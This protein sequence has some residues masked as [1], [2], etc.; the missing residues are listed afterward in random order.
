[1]TVRPL[2]SLAAV[3]LWL[4]L[5]ALW[6]AW[7]LVAAVLRELLNDVFKVRKAT[8]RRWVPL[9]RFPRWGRIRAWLPGRRRQPPAEARPVRRMSSRKRAN[10]V[11][12]LADRDGLYCQ[13]CGCGLDPTAHHRSNEH[14]EVHH[15]V[16]WCFAK[17]EPWCDTPVNLVLLCQRDNLAIGNGTTRR[18]EG[19]RRELLDYYGYEVVGAT[20]R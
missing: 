15:L 3:L 1:M 13:E 9:P 4:P 12:V 11:A 5:V 8:C 16:A 18:L 2:A 10:L 7:A 19:K 17:G 20:S 14:P 6:L